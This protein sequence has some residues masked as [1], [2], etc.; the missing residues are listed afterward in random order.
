MKRLR[1]VAALIVALILGTMAWFMVMLSAETEGELRLA[2]NL[3]TGRLLAR[4]PPPAGFLKFIVFG[5][6]NF[7]GKYI[8]PKT[9]IT[10]TLPH[11]IIHSAEPADANEEVWYVMLDPRDKSWEIEVTESRAVYLQWGGKRWRMGTKTRIWKTE[12]MSKWEGSPRSGS[13]GGS[14]NV[15]WQPS[16]IGWRASLD[17]G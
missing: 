6:P 16:S 12:R 3:S 4:V 2:R 9:G 13:R 1:R 15:R 14:G 17:A 8:Q 10:G 11:G 7:E 5:P